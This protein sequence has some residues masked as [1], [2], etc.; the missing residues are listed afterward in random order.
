MR[1]RLERN[2]I[3]LAVDQLG[4]REVFVGQPFILGACARHVTAVGLD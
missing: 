3:R 2:K 4:P 1:L